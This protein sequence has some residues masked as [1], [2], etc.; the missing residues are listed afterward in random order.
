L[1]NQTNATPSAF[2]AAGISQVYTV[3]EIKPTRRRQLLT[4][5]AMPGFNNVLV[6]NRRDAVS[7][8]L[9]EIL[10]YF[11]A[12]HIRYKYLRLSF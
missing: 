2:D 8:C 3:L 4:P 10:G 9:I 1:K 12:L 5:L 6:N 7:W 11:K